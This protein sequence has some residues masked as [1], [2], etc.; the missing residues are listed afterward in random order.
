MLT[1]TEIRNDLTATFTTTR[2]R[3]LYRAWTV[4]HPILAAYDTPLDAIDAAQTHHLDGD[5]ILNAFLAL[6]ATE[7]LARLAV[8]VAF[9]PWIAHH[10]GTHGA[11]LADRDDQIATLIAAVTEAAVVLAPG[12]PYLWPA[13]TIIHSA[14]KPIDRHYRRVERAVDPLGTSTDLERNGHV[15][16]LGHPR[17]GTTGPELVL[18]GLVAGLR[19]R[20]FTLED[21]A[22][23]AR[24]VVDGQSAR[25][26]S[27]G[28]YLT[29]RATQHRV[30]KIAYR[31]AAHAA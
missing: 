6:S 29:P 12:A 11:R 2:G 17:C 16:F 3:R 20:W 31:L 5:E 10:I 21:A 18:A 27:G 7:P 23:V 1:L 22:I 8:V 28:L 13:T 30:R 15:E 9:T 14:R 4:E 24:I 26:Q 19:A 25:T